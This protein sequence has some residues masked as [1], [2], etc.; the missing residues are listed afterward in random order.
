MSRFNDKSGGRVARKMKLAGD[1]ILR[2]MIIKWMDRIKDPNFRSIMDIGGNE[3]SWNRN[4]EKYLES[5]D[6]W[7]KHFEI[8]YPYKRASGGSSSFPPIPIRS[9]D[10]ISLRCS[11]YRN[12]EYCGPCLVPGSCCKTFWAILGGEDS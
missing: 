5:K 7:A 2:P 4:P 10:W 11:E 6:F 8:Y 1:K 9:T 3:R 12:W